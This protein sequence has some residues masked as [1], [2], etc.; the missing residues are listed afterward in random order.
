MGNHYHL[1]VHTRHPNLSVGM[2]FLNGTYARVFNG[3]HNRTGHVFESRFYPKV[4][5][6][7]RCLATVVRYVVANPVR[8]NLTTRALDWNWS[9]HHA[10]LGLRTHR[11]WFDRAAVLALFNNDESTAIGQYIVFVN[12]VANPPPW[13]LAASP[14]PGRDEAIVRAHHAGATAPAIA[15]DVGASLSTV[16]R[17]IRAARGHEVPGTS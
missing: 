4:I 12:E 8:A 10:V 1:V 13:E 7:Q 15:L 5:E 17:V 6:D 11:A 9:S 16:R 2:H 14:T 3:V